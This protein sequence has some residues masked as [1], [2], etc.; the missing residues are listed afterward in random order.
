MVSHF[1]FH[2]K[3]ISSSRQLLSKILLM[4][5]MVQ[6][7]TQNCAL[8]Y[9]FLSF[10]VLI[11]SDVQEFSVWCKKSTRNS[12]KAFNSRTFKHSVFATSVFFAVLVARVQKYSFWSVFLWNQQS[13]SRLTLS[14][15]MKVF[16]FVS[17]IPK[18]LVNVVFT[19][20]FQ[21]TL[22]SD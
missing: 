10:L 4:N 9:R 3:D 16:L 11:F 7:L 15:S 20:I 18:I 22:V 17:K 2:W 5:I 12:T 1:S 13:Q 6:I 19:C 8:F 14:T 21:K